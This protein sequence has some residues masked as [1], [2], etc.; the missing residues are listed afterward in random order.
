MSA[1][2][3]FLV[4]VLNAHNPHGTFLRLHDPHGQPSGARPRVRCEL[5]PLTRSVLPPAVAVMAKAPGVSP[6]KSRLHAALTAE[7]ATELYRCFLLDRLDA[8]AALE[9]VSA[10]IAFTPE[11][12]ERVVKELAPPGFRLIAQR[13]GD[14]G[15]RLSGLLAEL[16]ERGH[17][18]AIA[19]DS[20]SPTLPMRYVAEAAEVLAAGRGDVVLGPC[21]DGGYYLVGLGSPQPALFEDIA[22][23][24]DT[25]F[26]A[27]LEK[28][29]SRGL[30]VHVLPRWFDVDTEADLQRLHAEMMIGANRPARTCAFVQQLYARAGGLAKPGRA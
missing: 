21:D 10:V 23:S 11:E 18:G 25:V 12:A 5:E 24:T 17:A 19:I 8:V 6:V 29:H 1:Y 3:D 28:A 2:K 20:D 7:R 26:A 27:T 15:Q 16:L 22:W 14:L 13:G 9:N 30:S 4:N